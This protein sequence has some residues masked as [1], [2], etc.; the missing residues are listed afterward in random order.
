MPTRGIVSFFT[1]VGL[2]KYGLAL[3][4]LLVYR[5]VLAERL[6]DSARTS[7]AWGE[8]PRGKVDR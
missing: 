7:V 5:G 2:I 1:L 6:R 8:L 3:S 4:A